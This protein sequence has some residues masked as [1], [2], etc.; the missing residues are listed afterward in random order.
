VPVGC[1][2]NF[3]DQISSSTISYLGE[4]S[5]GGVA[6]E[7]KGHTAGQHSQCSASAQGEDRKIDVVAA[8]E[9]A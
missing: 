5:V 4:T 6:Q 3:M 9:A 1:G 8:G 7:E 2:T